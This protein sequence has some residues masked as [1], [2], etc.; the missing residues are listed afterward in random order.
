MKN[1]VCLLLLLAF[2]INLHA[3]DEKVTPLF[4]DQSTLS[5]KL[6]TSIKDIKK[7]TND[8]TYLPA[9]LY[10]KNAS[11]GWDSIKIEIRAR[12]IFRRKNCY[13]TPIRIKVSKD[14]AKGTILQGN[15]SL[16]LVMPCE[17]S[18]D[19]NDLVMKEYLCY[20]MFEKITPYY[21]N[22]RL[23]SLDFNEADGKK[24]KN[25]QLTAFLIEDD[26]LV[27]KRNKGEIM[28][29]LNLHPMRLNDT[30]SLKHDIFQYMIA[31]I[32][33]STTFLHN[34]KIMKQPTNRYIPLAYDFD[35]SGF[36][37]PPY[38]VP[39]SDLGQTDIRDRVYRGFCR[40]EPVV[41]AVRQ[42]YLKVEPD[43]MGTLA[44]YEKNF[45]PRDYNTMKKYVEEFYATMKDD[46][47]FKKKIV[48]G[49]RK[50]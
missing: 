37:N 17:N 5:L 32:D 15:K 14:N 4:A 1:I 40:N 43:V 23:V 31:N 3:Q 13:F 48:D 30:S 42:H 6:T 46:N 18:S 41:Q 47:A 24:V 20:K 21:F 34:A 35:M 36:V 39:N 10:V 38:G 27:A 29:N 11:G 2:S 7:K 49:C 44:A 33:W 8:S 16:K 9:Q 12:G 28:E 50:K 45:P 22:T 25:H 26:D 19:K